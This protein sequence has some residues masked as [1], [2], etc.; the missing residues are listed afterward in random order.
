MRR[1]PAQMS[2]QTCRQCGH[3]FYFEDLAEGRTLRCPDCREATRLRVADTPA[4]SVANTGAAV[5]IGLA[6]LI[7][8]KIV[9]LAALLIVFLVGWPVLILGGMVFVVSL[10]VNA[11]KSDKPKPPKRT[12]RPTQII[13][14]E[15][16]TSRR[17]SATDV[18]AES[19]PQEQEQAM[20]H[21]ECPTCWTE[22]AMT[23]AKRRRIAGQKFACRECGAVKRIPYPTLEH[24]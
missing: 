14:G 15:S 2:H 4:E 23:E 17:I 13:E 11:F 10:I 8:L 5:L 21:F 9:G 1:E 24:S 16:T 6:C 19:P 3:V 22:N 20:Y 12:R 18:A 7:G